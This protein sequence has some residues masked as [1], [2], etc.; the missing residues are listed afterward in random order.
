MDW[1]YL[2]RAASI[3]YHYINEWNSVINVNECRKQVKKKP[4]FLYSQY[5]KVFKNE[6]FQNPTLNVQFYFSMHLRLKKNKLAHQTQSWRSQYPQ[7]TFGLFC[8]KSSQNRLLNLFC[9][10]NLYFRTAHYILHN[11]ESAL[12]TALL[13]SLFRGLRKLTSG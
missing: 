1:L 7:F 11:T 5:M 13:F 8:P 2:A 4:D 9:Y 3:R 10:Y 12:L 6:F